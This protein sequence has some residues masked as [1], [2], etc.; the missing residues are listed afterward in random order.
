[1][2]DNILYIHGGGDVIGG[3]ENHIIDSLKYHKVYEPHIAIVKK[4]RFLDLIRS[5]GFQN[6]V[7]LDGGKLRNVYRTAKALVNG[8]IYIKKRNIKVIIANGMHSWI[9]GAML[10]KISGIKSVCY[11]T[12]EISK[13]YKNLIDEI[14]LLFKSDIAIANSNYTA[15]SISEFVNSPIEVVYP[16]SDYCKFE[17]IDARKARLSLL[18]EFKLKSDTF[19]FTIVGRIQK[20]KGQEVVIEAY[21]KMFNKHKAS[22]LIV[23]SY[24]FEKDLNYYNYLI[25]RTKDED[26][27]I[28]TGYRVDVPYIIMGS[29]A[30][31]HAT[32]TA[33]PFGVVL[34]EGMMSGKPVV[35]T[36][37][38][39]PKEI[40]R[41]NETG[42]LY[43]PGDINELS[44]IMDK[45][46]E[47]NYLRYNLSVK[48]KKYVH[49]KLS[50]N[51]SITKLE[52]VIS[53]I[54]I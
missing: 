38:G 36:S 52:K 7:Y 28:M 19:V 34:V 2:K 16:S 32:I 24:T 43:K 6:Y 12:N 9:Y 22:L 45:L 31:I 47:D 10:S 11:F 41:H 35:A 14:G 42:I 49:Q 1:L 44:G 20:W 26:S 17:N 33:E 29:N 37:A 30:I 51:V 15:K 4:G 13:G 54:L 53:K 39:G 46:I 5:S 3:I 21:K 50:F 23:G 8:V 27:I 18:G 48:S 40:I 25:E